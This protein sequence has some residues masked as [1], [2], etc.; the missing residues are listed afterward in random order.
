MLYAKKSCSAKKWQDRVTANYKKSCK[1]GYKM[2]ERFTRKT[3]KKDIAFE[4]AANMFISAQKGRGNSP[5]T[6]NHYERTIKNFVNFS[7]GLF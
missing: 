6:I 1:G 7:V 5:A 4:D 3:V 2:E